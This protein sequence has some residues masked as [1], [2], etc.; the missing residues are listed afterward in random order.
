MSIFYIFLK[1]CLH[2]WYAMQLEGG[3]KN[4]PEFFKMM[5]FLFP[6][7]LGH[8]SPSLVESVNEHLRILFS[9]AYYYHNNNRTEHFITIEY[10]MVT[11]RSGKSTHVYRYPK[12]D[13]HPKGGVKCAT[14]FR[15]GKTED[16]LKAYEEY[17]RKHRLAF[18]R[19]STGGKAPRKQLTSINSATDES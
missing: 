5:C 19:R 12:C 6:S 17:C 9:P 11:T 7:R 13:R 8:I 10:I 18:P 2:K 3:K 1:F 15:A 16:E 14:C 4:E